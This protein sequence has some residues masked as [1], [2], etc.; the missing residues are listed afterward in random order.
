MDRR[1]GP[2]QFAP[3]VCVCGGGGGKWGVGTG[4]SEFFYYECKFLFLCVCGGGGE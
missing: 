1:T 2:N 3:F 4:V